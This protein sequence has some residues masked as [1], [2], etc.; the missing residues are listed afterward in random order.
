M[1]TIRDSSRFNISIVYG[2]NVEKGLDTYLRHVSNLDEKVFLKTETSSFEPKDFCCVEFENSQFEYLEKCCSVEGSILVV[3]TSELGKV[4]MKNLL[5]LC[6]R[7]R[8]MF[9]LALKDHDAAFAQK[10][11]WSIKSHVRCDIDIVQCKAK[12]ICCETNGDVPNSL[13]FEYE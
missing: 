6:A 2:K 3:C 4:E 10:Q 9:I 5:S 13:E 7:R 8:V 1:T 11:L 12:K